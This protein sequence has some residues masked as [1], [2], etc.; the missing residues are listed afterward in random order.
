[1][2]IDICINLSFIIVYTISST[3]LVSLVWLGWNKSESNEHFYV[4]IRVIKV[5]ESY[6]DRGRAYLIEY[7]IF[8]YLFWLSTLI[9]FIFIYHEQYAVQKPWYV[10]L[11]YICIQKRSFDFI[12][13]L[14]KF[15]TQI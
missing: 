13:F 9:F 4:L 14:F 1:M 5:R 2:P 7:S 11:Y 15:V 10:R 6:L 3:F 12:N 8:L